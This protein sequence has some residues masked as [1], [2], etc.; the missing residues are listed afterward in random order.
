MSFRNRIQ[1]STEVSQHFGLKAKNA[2]WAA[3][4]VNTC[5]CIAL[6]ASAAHGQKNGPPRTQGGIEPRMDPKDKVPAEVPVVTHHSM[7]LRGRVLEY[8]ATTA[9]D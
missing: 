7:T 6:F 1:G 2:V 3:R 8:T 4:I 9:A 5:L